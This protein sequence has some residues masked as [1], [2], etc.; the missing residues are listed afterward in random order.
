MDDGYISGPATALTAGTEVL[1]EGDSVSGTFTVTAAADITV[2]S[3]YLL[4]DSNAFAANVVEITVP[5]A[6]FGDIET[7]SNINQ[8]AD[9]YSPAGN[10]L[11]LW[12]DM[13]VN[14]G[15][16]LTNEGTL[17]VSEGGVLNNYG[18]ITNDDMLIVTGYGTF[19]NYSADT[20][21]NNG[22][23]I[24]DAYG[25]LN[26]GGDAGS[27]RI[28]NGT[29]ALFVNNGSFLIAAG[30]EMEN[31]GTLILKGSSDDSEFSG[32]VTE[33]GGVVYNVG[34]LCGNSTDLTWYLEPDTNGTYELCI[35]GSGPIQDYISEFD[36]NQVQY[37][38]APWYPFHESI[39]S[40]HLSDGITAIGE[41]NFYKLRELVTANIPDSVQ[42]IGECAFCDAEKLTGIEI[43]GSVKTIGKYAFDECFTMTSLTLNEGIETIVDYA[44]WYCRSL[45]SVHIPDSVQTMGEYA[46]SNCDALTELSFGS[47]LTTIAEA[48]FRSCTSLEVLTI[49]DNIT[50]IGSQAFC[51]CTKLETVNFGSGLT[52][53]ANSAFSSCSALQEITIPESVTSLGTSVFYG[54]R[55]L[56]DIHVSEDNPSYSSVNGVVF[57]KDKTSLIAYPPGKTDASYTIP[58]GV[59][60]IADNAFYACSLLQE[61]SFPDSVV[62]IG[63]SAFRD[64]T[65]LVTLNISNDASQLSTIGYMAFYGCN[66]LANSNGGNSLIFPK[67]IQSVGGDAFGECKNLTA[68]IFIGNDEP[69]YSI[70]D[71][72]FCV[73]SSLTTVEFHGNVTSIGS[74]AFNSTRLTSARF[75]GDPPSLEGDSQFGYNPT[76]F[77]VYYPSNNGNWVISDGKWGGYT[78]VGFD[79]ALE[80]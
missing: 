16:T 17:T 5:S 76:D 78:A 57:T 55:S 18:T 56:T 12:G 66:K 3:A 36:A 32:T 69:G 58:S 8:T 47:G 52:T 59:T 33:M 28:I 4:L 27:G 2:S 30:S 53:I 29:D 35:T 14:A 15:T 24:I 65:E 26:N 62:A 51:V 60:A 9:L 79:S 25:T 71:S 75:Y 44:F 72:A 49:P 73:C 21:Y 40:L 38:T 13:T 42:S 31:S 22:A 45:P 34:G 63:R 20:L 70:G 11:L 64:C 23:L 37:S 46:F 39:V 41:Y 7:E 19:N 61:V 48:A 1:A 54:C 50:L 74:S 68:V 67:S 80:W 43:P 10:S 6:I 77:T